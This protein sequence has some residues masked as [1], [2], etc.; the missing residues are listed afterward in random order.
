MKTN[1]LKKLSYAPPATKVFEM[2]MSIAMLAST[3]VNEIN[4]TSIEELE[5]GGEF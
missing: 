1:L 4:G 5:D 2:S 3:Y